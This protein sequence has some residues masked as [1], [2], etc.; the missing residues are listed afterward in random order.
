MK[1]LYRTLSAEEFA[2]D[3]EGFTSHNDNLLAVEQLLGHNAGQATKEMSLAVDD[4]LYPSQ[5]SSQFFSALIIE[6]AKSQVRN[7]DLTHHWLES[8]HRALSPVHEANI[9]QGDELCS[10]IHLG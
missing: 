5:E 2:R 8:G 7:K 9:Q 6:N 10:G 4:D 1:G 3:V